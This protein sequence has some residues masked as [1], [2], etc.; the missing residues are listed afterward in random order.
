MKQL[1][2]IKLL[3][4]IGMS[5]PGA[6]N[7]G[8]PLAST[9]FRKAVNFLYQNTLNPLHISGGVLIVSIGIC[10]LSMFTLILLVSALSA[11]FL[12]ITIALISSLIIFNNIVSR[13]SKELALIEK[14]TPYVLEELAT[15]F[16]TTG[17]VFEAIQYVAKGEYGIISTEFAKMIN[18]LNSGVRPEQLLKNFAIQQPSI[19]LRRGLFTFIQFIE[20]TTNSL[21]AVITESHEN[22]QRRYERLTFQWES[23]MMVYSGLL[24]FLP[25]IIVL[26]I[27]IRGFADN[28]LILLLPIFHY[29]L[30]KILLSILLPNDLILL[31]E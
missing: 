19:T 25:I 27:A 31:G 22:L 8:K 24:V 30:S 16:L 12:S 13:Y 5:V 10:I 3:A 18:S 11:V 2:Y 20:S 6:S 4:K 7:F 29:A 1:D 9:E 28:P 17:S 14:A 26:G 15:L 23:R 21:D